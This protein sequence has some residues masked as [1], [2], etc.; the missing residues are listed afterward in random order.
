MN[1]MAKG[2]NYT[3]DGAPKRFK[4]NSGN[5]ASTVGLTDE[6]RKDFFN[7]F[8][9]SRPKMVKISR[10]IEGRERLAIKSSPLLVDARQK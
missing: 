9:I 6:T 4:M 10:R 2:I 5:Q 8:L 3:N 1:Y 7:Q